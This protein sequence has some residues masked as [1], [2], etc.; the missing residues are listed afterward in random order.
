MAVLTTRR[1]HLTRY[2]ATAVNFNNYGAYRLRVEVTA[3]EGADL[4]EFI[5]VYKR[6]PPS[7]YTSQDCDTFEA[8]AGPAQ[9]ASIP[10][11][12]PNPDMEWPYYR[13]NYVELDVQSATQADSIWTEIQ[14]EAC[15]LVSAMEKLSSLQSVESVWC[16]SPPDPGSTSSQSSS[17]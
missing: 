12:S 14:A 11:G 1:I 6:N 5:F 9:L 15:T 17:V 7:P 8:V 4:D 10:A 13:L 16:P 3:V 2:A